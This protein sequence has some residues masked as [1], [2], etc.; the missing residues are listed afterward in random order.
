LVVRP[1]GPAL[2]SRSECRF[3]R[4]DASENGTYARCVRSLA[5][6]LVQELAGVLKPGSFVEGDRTPS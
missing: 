3:V 2:S 4:D 5:E 1:L 6:L